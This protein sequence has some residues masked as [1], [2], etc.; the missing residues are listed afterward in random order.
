MLPD[1]IDNATP[2]FEWANDSQTILYTTQDPET[3]RW[4]RIF[5][6][7]LGGSDD[8]LVY[9]ESDDT[10]W[11]WLEKSLSSQFLFLVSAATVA[12]EVR[13]LPASSPGQRPL[14]SCRARVSMNTLSLMAAIGFSY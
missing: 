4:N 10:S 11:L 2:N 12:T 9:E 8:S 1:R 3:L 7:T 14:P 6:H 5:R 13:Y